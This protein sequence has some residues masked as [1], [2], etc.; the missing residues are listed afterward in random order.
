MVVQ[1]SPETVS[2]VRAI[3]DKPF[4]LMEKR[5]DWPAMAT[6]LDA[7][8]RANEDVPGDV[9][10]TWRLSGVTSKEA[11]A[12]GRL[13]DRDENGRNL[14]ATIDAGLAFLRFL[15]GWVS[16]VQSHGQVVPSAEALRAMIADVESIRSEA[17]DNWPWTPTKEEWEEAIAEF[18]R[19]ESVDID[20]AFAAANGLSREEWLRLVEDRRRALAGGG[21]R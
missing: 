15:D 2:V 6:T 21:D 20:D 18:E 11:A 17:L 10:E 14:A 5:S 9:R 12:N 3:L 4:R 16:A 19:G 7:L 8:I 13:I 1:L